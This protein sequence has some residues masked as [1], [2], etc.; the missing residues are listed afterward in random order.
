MQRVKEPACMAENDEAYRTAK[1]NPYYIN[2][3]ELF[4]FKISAEGLENDVAHALRWVE[5][6]RGCRYMACANPHSLV[7]ASRDELFRK[8]LREAD[9]LTP[10]G[11]GVVLACGFLNLPLHN[12][13]VGYDFFMA[14]TKRMAAKG[15]IRFFFLGSSDRVLQLIVER[16][17]YEFP[18]INVCG[19]YTPPF[20]DAFSEDENERMVA[21]VNAAEPDVLWVGMTAPKQEKWIFENRHKLRVSFTSGIGAVFEFYAGTAE[22]APIVWQRMGLEWFYRFAR[23]PSRLWERNLV[24]TPKFIIMVLKEKCRQ[25]F[26]T[27]FR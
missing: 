26:G 14:L 16:M 4:D 3:V 23:E 10:D 12:R 5:E 20:S 25:L 27:S 19:T 11:V 17:N 2:T 7:V 22:R 13:V 21:A 1:G 18:S 15:G 6:R 9:L 24:S 8:S